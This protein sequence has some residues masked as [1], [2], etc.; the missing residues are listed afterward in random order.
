M[1]KDEPR[2]DDHGESIR[3]SVTF[4]RDI[5]KTIELIAAEKKVSVAWVVRDATEKYLSE[6][7]PLLR[8]SGASP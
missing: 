1:S 2:K 3:A 5:Y 4:P 7:W 8:N 6:R